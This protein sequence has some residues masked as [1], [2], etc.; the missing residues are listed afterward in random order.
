M[1]DIAMPFEVS[2]L[3]FQ[4]KKPATNTPLTNLVQA[5]DVY[6]WVALIFSYISVTLAMMFI[7]RHDVLMGYIKV[8]LVL[9]T[10]FKLV[11]SH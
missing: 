2:S 11:T 10:K 8:L 3:I 9:F 7:G 1:F 5:F 6:V 4:Q